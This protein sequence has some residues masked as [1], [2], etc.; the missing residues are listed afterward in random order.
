M[1][2]PPDP[3]DTETPS[4]IPTGEE[5]TKWLGDIRLTPEQHQQIKDIVH[6]EQ[7]QRIKSFDRRYLVVGTGEDSAAGRR[8]QLVYELLDTRTDPAAVATQ[9]EDYDLTKEEMDVWVRVFD[10]LCGHATHISA[11]IE[12]FDGGYVWELGLLFAPS[13]RP[14]TWVLKRRYTDSETEREHFDNGMAASHTTLLLTG[15]RAIEWRTEHELRTAVE[16]IP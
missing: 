2:D 14:K 13:Y 10:L 15:D 6:G 4:D 12:D 11:V 1:D 9:L 16:R 7:F 3:P 5:V 8:R